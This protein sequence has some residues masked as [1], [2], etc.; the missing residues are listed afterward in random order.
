M[1]AGAT[2][3]VTWQ[4]NGSMNM[5][6]GGLVVNST[7]IHV[8]STE[9]LARS[10]QVHDSCPTR[11]DPHQQQRA[12]PQAAHTR[13]CHAHF[14]YIDLFLRQRPSKIRQPA[15]HD[16]GGCDHDEEARLESGTVIACRFRMNYD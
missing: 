9:S 16:K 14:N 7:R 2:T 3:F 4:T 6:F 8:E 13:S 15:D 10:D 11:P 1:R 12:T 5:K